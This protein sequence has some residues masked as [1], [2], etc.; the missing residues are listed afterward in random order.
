MK[1]SKS[2]ETL[3]PTVA[4][5]NITIFTRIDFDTQTDELTG[6]SIAYTNKVSRQ[7]DKLVSSKWGDLHDYVEATL[8]DKIARIEYDNKKSKVEVKKPDICGKRRLGASA[9]EKDIREAK[10]KSPRK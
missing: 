6:E 5:G 1:I 10:I 3:I 8:K 7:L 2:I 9:G 4:Y